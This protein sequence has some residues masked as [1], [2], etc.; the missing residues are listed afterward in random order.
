MVIETEATLHNHDPRKEDECRLIAVSK[1][2]EG[3]SRNTVMVVL[4]FRT[5]SRDVSR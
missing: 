5:P 2:G 1:A 4:Y 3:M